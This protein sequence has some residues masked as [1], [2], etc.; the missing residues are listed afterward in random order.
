MEWTAAEILTATDAYNKT[1]DDPRGQGR[2]SAL[3]ELVSLCRPLTL[4]RSRSEARRGHGSRRT[5]AHPTS[6]APLLRLA[7]RADAAS[8]PGGPLDRLAQRAAKAGGVGSSVELLAPKGFR[9]ATEK[10][11][12]DYAGDF[13]MLNDL[14]RCSVVVPTTLRLGVRAGCSRS[15]GARTGRGEGRRERSG[16]RVARAAGRGVGA[17]GGRAAGGAGGGAAESDADGTPR[18]QPLYV[19]DRLGPD[20]AEWNSSYR[21]ILIV[22]QLSCDGGALLNV[23]LVLHVKRLYE[24]RK[25]LHLLYDGRKALGE[26]NSLWHVG[27]SQPRGDLACLARPRAAAAV[28]RP[29]DPVDDTAKDA[30]RELLSARLAISTRSI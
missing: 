2:A 20:D 23:E 19:K 25:Q 5:S 6:C 30:L 12:A 14:A 28:P 3:A 15:G 21:Y 29:P 11:Q 22:G 10:A 18:F 26:P 7:E 16:R 27:R 9:R 24:Q 4:K 17:A 8:R 13:L 1:Y